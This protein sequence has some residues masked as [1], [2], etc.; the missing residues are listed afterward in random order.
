MSSVEP[1]RAPMLERSRR[2][3]RGLSPRPSALGLA[4]RLYSDGVTGPKRTVMFLK[5]PVVTQPDPLPGGMTNSGA[6]LEGIPK[7]WCGINSPSPP[8]EVSLPSK[9]GDPTMS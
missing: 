2:R 1:R 7:P 8:I 4:V 3:Q 9:S 6:S 5:G